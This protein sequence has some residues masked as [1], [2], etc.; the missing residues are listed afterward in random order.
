MVAG[1]IVVFSYTQVIDTTLLLVEVAKCLEKIPFGVKVD[2]LFCPF[3]ARWEP[4]EVT[5]LAIAS[6]FIF[7][8]LYNQS[9]LQL[10]ALS[11]TQ[12]HC[13]ATRFNIRPRNQG[14]SY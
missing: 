3:R 14:I 5:E 9:P 13:C 1:T 6:S 8:P 11:S 4:L 2:F 10:T 7:G 12:P